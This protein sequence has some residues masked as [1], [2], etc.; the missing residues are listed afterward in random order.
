MSQPRLFLYDAARLAKNKTN[1]TLSVP[2]NALIAN[3]DDALTVGPV[4]CDG[5]AVYT[6]QR[7]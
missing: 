1:P 7:G 5:Q 6:P 2:L 4:F 3:A